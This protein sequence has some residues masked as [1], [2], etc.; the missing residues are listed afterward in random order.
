MEMERV[1]IAQRITWHG[2]FVNLLLTIGKILAGIFGN[3]AAMLADAVRGNCTVQK[4]RNKLY[5]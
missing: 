4:L 2:F 3:S 5:E 1:K